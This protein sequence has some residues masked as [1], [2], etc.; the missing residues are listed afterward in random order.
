MVQLLT[1]MV[2][3]ILAVHLESAIHK[4]QCIAVSRAELR[5]IE[6][7][8]TVPGSCR[9]QR[10]MSDGNDP[11]DRDIRAGLLQVCLEPF[12]LMAESNSVWS[13]TT[14]L[15]RSDHSPAE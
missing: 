11:I 7:V 8:F 1:Y 5:C 2:H 14:V 10:L 4:S 3:R 6:Q 12:E 15:R 13:A 9:V